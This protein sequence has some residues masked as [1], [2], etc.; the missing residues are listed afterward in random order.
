MSIQILEQPGS[1]G[2][3]IG[4]SL[5]RS[6]A[7]DIPKEVGRQRL[8]ASLRNIQQG[9]LSP[10]EQLANLVG[11][12]GAEASEAAQFLPLIQKTQGQRALLNRVAGRSSGT[13][14]ISPVGQSQPGQPQ[15]KTQ[16]MGMAAAPTPKSIADI[17]SEDIKETKSRILQPISTQDIEKEAAMLIDSNPSL[18]VNEA[19]DQASQRLNTARASQQQKMTG[20][21]EEFG[22]RMALELQGEGL[23]DY[24]DISGDIQQDLS[25]KIQTQIANGISAERAAQEASEIARELARSSTKLKETSSLFRSSSSKSRALKEQYKTYKNYGYGEQFRQMASGMLGITPQKVAS[26]LEP[27]ERP[28]MKKALSKI[29]SFQFPVNQAKTLEKIALEVKPTDNL[30]SI[31]DYLRDESIDPNSFF[32]IVRNLNDQN[33]LPLTNEQNKQ[34]KTN[35]SKG[36]LGDILFTLF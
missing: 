7:E 26:I 34:L 18:S 28:E 16:D 1:L 27:I 3:Q 25:D 31:A 35:V 30:L 6:L 23:G 8:A 11:S 9:N 36:Y 13:L 5:G 14:G 21:V 12:G 20:A 19:M 17:T 32:K 22:K 15:V 4:Q 10:S 29:T 33:K 24:K 2:T